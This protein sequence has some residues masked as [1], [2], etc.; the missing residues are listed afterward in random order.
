[1][2]HNPNPSLTL[3]KAWDERVGDS[4]ELAPKQ[5][6]RWVESYHN[7]MELKT[8]L[9]FRIQHHALLMQEQIHMERK[10]YLYPSPSTVYLDLNPI[11]PAILIVL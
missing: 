6:E 9:E 7:F 1:M 2:S 3:S 4:L 11:I 8:D 5:R 10:A